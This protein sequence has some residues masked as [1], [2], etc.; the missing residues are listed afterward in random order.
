MRSWRKALARWWF[1][2]RWVQE[3]WERRFATAP[4]PEDIPW[5][6]LDKPLSACRLALVSTGGIHLNSDKRF[7][8]SDP[9]GDPSFRVIPSQVNSTQLT[10]T[11]DYYDHRDADQD[12]NLV[13][14]LDPMRALVMEGRIGDLAPSAFSLMGHIHG[15]HLE[16]LTQATAPAIATRMLEENVR[17]ALLVPA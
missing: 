14:P 16:E 9:D 7:D 13:L 5:T 3:T 15:R 1:R 17:A 2:W 6:P 10:I 12:S 8:M 4:P 11:H